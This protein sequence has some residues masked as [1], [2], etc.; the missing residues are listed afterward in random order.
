MDKPVEWTNSLVST[1]SMHHKQTCYSHHD[2]L[3]LSEQIPAEAV[4]WQLLIWLI[5][6][7][8]YHKMSTFLVIVYF[9]DFL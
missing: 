2:Q 7:R 6:F 9:P 5:L 3:W 4:Y 8:V 1:T